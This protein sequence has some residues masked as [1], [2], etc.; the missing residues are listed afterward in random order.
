LGQVFA[1]NPNLKKELLVCIAAD[2]LTIKTEGLSKQKE[3]ILLIP[4]KSLKI[5]VERLKPGSK[6]LIKKQVIIK[7]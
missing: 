7:N 3:D 4:S 2:S 5:L 1:Q 6:E